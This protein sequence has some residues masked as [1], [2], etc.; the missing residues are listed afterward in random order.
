M[1]IEFFLYTIENETVCVWNL[2]HVT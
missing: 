2:W 1:N